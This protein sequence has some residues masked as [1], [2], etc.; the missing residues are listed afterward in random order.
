MYSFS[1]PAMAVL[2]VVAS[3]CAHLMTGRVPRRD[4]R[5]VYHAAM[6]VVFC[7]SM[8][9][10]LVVRLEFL[11]TLAMLV[12]LTTLYIWA[13]RRIF[14]YEALYLACLFFLCYDLSSL[15][16]CNIAMGALPEGPLSLG[17]TERDVILVA[18]ST[19]VLLGS[20]AALHR[21]FIGDLYILPPIQTLLI[22]VPMVPYAYVR[23][24]LYI[25]VF[26]GGVPAQYTGEIVLLAMS[27][28]PAFVQMVANKVFLGSATRKNDVLQ[29]QAVLAA[30]HQQ[31]LIK[32]ETIDQVNRYYHDMKHF[33]T[34]IGGGS[35][36]GETASRRFEENLAMYSPFVDTGCPIVDVLVGE[37]IQYCSEHGIRLVPFM[38]ARSLADMD[39]LDLCTLFGNA[40]DNA[41]EAVE[42]LPDPDE[43][44]IRAKLGVHGGFT[45]FTLENPYLQTQEPGPGG[46]GAVPHGDGAGCRAHHG[47]GIPNMRRVAETHGGSLQ[48]QAD[49]GVFRLTVVLPLFAA[50]DSP[51]A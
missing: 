27:F 11:Y 19:V 5:P 10:A 51:V 40:F 48:L 20:T 7:A 50:P 15:L 37:K 14:L 30:Q 1:A 43:R 46:E 45:V 16:V 42:Q 6:L 3:I 17:Q 24:G 23:S 2:A 44:E 34:L 32:R 41:I 18:G 31:Y 29:M 8:V 36:D 47:Y 28:V 22:V 25:T 35:A 4:C 26:N 9:A 13:V 21:W 12:P 33:A 38:D 49:D 39:P